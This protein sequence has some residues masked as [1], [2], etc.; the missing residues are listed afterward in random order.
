M[1]VV[2]LACGALAGALLLMQVTWYCSAWCWLSF[3]AAEYDELL[4][5]IDEMQQKAKKE[6]NENPSLIAQYGHSGLY[7]Y[8]VFIYR[9]RKSA[10]VKRILEKADKKG[11]KPRD[12]WKYEAD[13]GTYAR[14]NAPAIRKMAQHERGH[15][16]HDVEDM[17]S[18]TKR[19]DL[20]KGSTPATVPLLEV[21]WTER[22]MFFKASLVNRDAIKQ[23]LEKI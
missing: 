1:L 4:S 18:Q 5:S 3:P 19:V 14:T 6:Y 22:H 12:E 7:S 11:F 20:L 17:L 21:K 10:F 8:F 15:Q 23:A 9:V 13:E 16:I 2:I